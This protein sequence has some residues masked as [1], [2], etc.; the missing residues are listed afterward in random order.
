MIRVLNLDNPVP[1]IIAGTSLH[2]TEE[3]AERDLLRLLAGRLTVRVQPGL[4]FR[5]RKFV[6]GCRWV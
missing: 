2:A 6:G 3:L 4:K 5:Y 1:V